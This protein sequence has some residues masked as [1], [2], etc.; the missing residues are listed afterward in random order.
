MQYESPILWTPFT[1]NALQY[2]PP[3]LWTRYNMTHLY[4]ERPTIWTTYTVNALG[5]EHFSDRKFLLFAI[6]KQLKN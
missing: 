4:R 2:E 3:V 6:V 1:V 5:C